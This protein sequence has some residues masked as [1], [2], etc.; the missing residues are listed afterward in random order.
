MTFVYDVQRREF[1]KLPSVVAGRKELM[2]RSASVALHPR[3]TISGCDCTA[4]R[5]GSLD[6][7][8]TFEVPHPPHRDPGLGQCT[9]I[10]TH[11]YSV[12]KFNVYH[13]MSSY[14]IN[15]GTNIDAE[16]YANGKSLRFEA[17]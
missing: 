9:P 7:D 3:Q 14:G 2:R 4:G 15:F 1:I 11:I 13:I 12:K 10:E 6:P 8:R 16:Y 17:N 5:R